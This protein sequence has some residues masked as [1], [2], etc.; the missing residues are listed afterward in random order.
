MKRQ[1]RACGLLVA[2]ILCASAWS[3]ERAGQHAWGRR[4]VGERDAMVVVDERPSAFK[5]SARDWTEMWTKEA[6]QEP[7]RVFPTLG[8]LSV[9][10]RWDPPLIPSVAI[11]AAAS[12]RFD[13]RLVATLDLLAQR[14]WKGSMGKAALLAA[15]DEVLA[16]RAASPSAGSDE[17]LARVR[18]ARSLGGLTADVP[19]AL[20]P[21]IEKL[22]ADFDARPD[23]SKPVGF[24][25]WSPVLS[26]LF[27]QDRFLQ[28]ACE[29]G[30]PEGAWLVDAANAVGSDPRLADAYRA[31]IT[32]STT[33]ADDLDAR[34]L[35]DVMKSPKGPAAFLPASRSHEADLLRKL[36]GGRPIPDGHA[37]MDDLVA[38]IRG[39]QVVLAPRPESGW[40]DWQTWALEPLVRAEAAAESKKVARDAGYARHCED[41]F[42]ALLTQRRET[43]TKQ[44][45]GPTC[46]SPAQMRIV[47]EITL[48]PQ[49]TVYRRMADSYRFVREALERVVGR[50]VL[51]AEPL[52]GP[53]GQERETILGGLQRMEQH[54][55]GLAALACDEIGGD[56]SFVGEGVTE[57]AALELAAKARLGLQSVLSPELLAYD[58]RV[59]VPIGYDVERN[60]VRC[61]AVVGFASRDFEVRY[62]KDPAVSIADASGA[63]ID[64]SKVAFY[65]DLNVV[66]APYEVWIE[67]SLKSP[68]TREE[69]RS[70]CDRCTNLA[71][72]KAALG[73]VK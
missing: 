46:G 21:R 7:S 58:P 12:K 16:K 41:V 67:C 26:R 32:L 38:A 8:G 36:Y 68:L 9:R 64:G 69:L 63:P 23:L 72:I 54:Y 15:V 50:D 51:A 66:R 48:E 1:Q 10:S 22:V 56:P 57:K 30:G 70:L 13:D 61:W 42:K 5:I 3:Q 71:Q 17:A 6:E 20:G 52:V 33:L 4:V 24:Y 31:L 29:P 62:A 60:E 45:S 2:V 25:T 35:L 47:P 44:L 55:R 18:A 53:G 11:L 28:S 73:A 65:C 19:A 43:H 37:I 27:R 40:Y 59:M 39:G 14:G 49:V 34:S